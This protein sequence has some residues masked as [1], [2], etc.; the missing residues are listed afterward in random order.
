MTQLSDE[1][2]LAYADGA[3]DSQEAAEVARLL[4]EDQEARERLRQLELGGRLARDAFTED[5]QE[6]VPDRLAD[7]LLGDEGEADAAE[8]PE[9]QP[10]ERD[11][12]VLSFRRKRAPRGA[13]GSW[14]MPLAASVALAVGLAGGVFGERILGGGGAPAATASLAAGPVPADSA[15]HAALQSKASY[16]EVGRGD[17]RVTPLLSFRDRQGRYCREY[18]VVAGTEAAGGIACREAG[19]WVATAVVAFPGQS[20]GDIT[21]ASGPAADLLSTVLEQEIEGAPLDP[22]QEKAAIAAGWSR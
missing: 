9:P 7:L 4:S 11:G 21:T 15:L 19:T 5:L 18:Q 8:E 17:S 10:A 13:L 22:E 3:L 6:P 16:E 2:L 14:A 20:G 1:T 12:E